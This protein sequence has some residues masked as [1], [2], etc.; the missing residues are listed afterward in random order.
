MFVKGYAATAANAALEP[1]E[2][3]L[4]PIGRAEV[5]IE[6]EYCGICHSDLS[7]IENA[8]QMTQFP[9]IPGHEVV[10]KIRAVGEDVKHLRPGTRVGVGWF[11]RSCMS[12]SQCMHGD[13]NLC[14]TAEGIIVG[15]H[16]GFA[17]FVRVDSS[18]AVPLPD[19]IPAE[20][21]GPLFCGGITVFNPIVQCGI[22]PTERV[23]VI[24][25]GGLGHMALAFLNAWG[26][27][28]TAFSSSESKESEARQLGAHHFVNS[29]D[30]A[31]LKK[32]A[33]SLDFI[34]STVNVG[35]DWE[36]YLGTLK[37]R[38]RLHFVGAVLEPIQVGAMS[39]IMGQKS[40]S[41][42]PLGSPATIEKMLEFTARH[43]I[44]PVTELYPMSK[45]NDAFEKLKSGSPRYRLVVQARQ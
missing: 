12:C 41:G 33:S 19:S 31:S 23:G 25:I 40:I 21:A 9:F 11:S 43:D 30:Q 3:E 7:M 26:C 22:E 42:S 10:G 20:S 37:P 6:V 13:H 16:G 36:T 17:D 34:I 1:F 5:D 24:G 8:W 18:W 27:E 29:R 45:I 35:L 14:Q 2:Y 38:G 44:K 28:V 32:A 4:G 15:R 39:M